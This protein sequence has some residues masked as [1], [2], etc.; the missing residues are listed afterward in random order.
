V[1][2][3]LETRAFEARLAAR[4]AGRA[5]EYDA[6]TNLDDLWRLREAQARMA[7]PH[8]PAKEWGVEKEWLGT[9]HVRGWCM[10]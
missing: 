4:A 10:Q 6:D 5:E 1:G 9:A 7:Q 2:P 3:A 8:W